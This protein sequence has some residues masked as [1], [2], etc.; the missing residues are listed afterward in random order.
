MV[1]SEGC[2][3]ADPMVSTQIR[4]FLSV[5]SACERRSIILHIAIPPYIL[6]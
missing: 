3:L 4:A 1:V 5:R 2:L 6:P